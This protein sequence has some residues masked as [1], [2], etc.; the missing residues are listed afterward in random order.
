[1]GVSLLFVIGERSGTIFP[2]PSHRHRCSGARPTANP[3]RPS[4]PRE[5]PPPRR[6]LQGLSVPPSSGVATSGS[7][8]IRAVALPAELAAVYPYAVHDH[9][10]TP[11]ERNLRSRLAA[12]LRH[13]HR[14]C[15]QPRPP[16]RAPKQDVG[17]FV[18]RRAH[19]RVAALGDFPVRSTSP[20]CHLRGAKPEVRAHRARARK[21]RRHVDTRPEGQRSHRTYPGTVI[22][23][24][25]TGSTRTASGI[26][27][28]SRTYSAN[29]AARARS[30]GFSAGPP[31]P[32][33][34][35]TPAR[36]APG[37]TGGISGGR[38]ILA[39]CGS[40]CGYFLSGISGETSF[41][42][43]T[44]RTGADGSWLP[45]RQSGPRRCGRYASPGLGIL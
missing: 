13:T 16:R 26:I 43:Y 28:C 3:L 4:S 36:E 11:G 7:R 8:S 33:A 25:Q 12:T 38:E 31:A 14:P 19:H 30:I 10:E 1:M 5:H 37:G 9:T 27:L 32:G 40:Y 20:D 39:G 6:K 15:L 17:R 42:Q 34:P 44:V 22:R 21:T 18:E 45:R 24:R 23:R 2:A 29:N 41:L 35:G